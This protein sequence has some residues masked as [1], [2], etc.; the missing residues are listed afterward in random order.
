MVPSTSSVSYQP[1]LTLHHGWFLHI[2]SVR[3]SANPIVRSSH[4][5]GLG[6]LSR[7]QLNTGP[8]PSPPHGPPQDPPDPLLRL[9]I[10]QF[11]ELFSQFS[12]LSRNQFLEFFSQFPESCARTVIEPPAKARG[13]CATCLIHTTWLRQLAHWTTGSRKHVRCSRLRWAGMT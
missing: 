6:D 2:I 3:S 9:S 11:L 8:P 4:T 13:H 7:P 12:D 5:S 1:S 10:N